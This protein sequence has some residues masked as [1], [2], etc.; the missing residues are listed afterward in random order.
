MALSSA[1]NTGKPQEPCNGTRH[2]GG[3]S[4]RTFNRAM[5]GCFQ[6]SLMLSL[7]VQWVSL[8]KTTDVG[9]VTNHRKTLTCSSILCQWAKRTVC[10]WYTCYRALVCACY[11]RDTMRV[12]FFIAA[13]NTA[14]S[15]EQ[16]C[17]GLRCTYMKRRC[18]CTRQGWGHVLLGVGDIEL[19]EMLTHW[20][21][22]WTSR[23]TQRLRPLWRRWLHE[24]VMLTLLQNRHITWI[25]CKLS[26]LKFL[27]HFCRHRRVPQVRHVSTRN[28]QLETTCIIKNSPMQICRFLLFWSRITSSSFV[29]SCSGFWDLHP[30]SN[31]LFAKYSYLPLFEVIPVPTHRKSGVGGSDSYK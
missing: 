4:R 29:F 12:Q 5:A 14:R 31:C 6:A 13:V 11:M 8:G 3:T 30:V 2:L 18:E 27:P 16:T 24:F 1:T 15:A 10:K 25:L 28:S 17:K 26:I 19:Q 21:P 7:S 22:E 20:V 23:F 9:P